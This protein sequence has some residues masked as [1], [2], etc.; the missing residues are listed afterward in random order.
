MRMLLMLLLLFLPTGA[1]SDPQSLYEGKLKFTVPEGF[2]PMSRELIAVKFPRANAP[3]HVY[4]DAKT[5]TSIAFTHSVSKLSDE[6]LEEFLGAM[7]SMLPGL[8]PGLKWIKKEIVVIQD[9]RWACLEFTTP[10]ADSVIHNEILATPMGGR[11]LLVNLNTVDSL[12]PSVESKL[13]AVKAS[14]RLAP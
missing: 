9:H 12:L 3:Q 4:A 2:Q 7:V 11:A 5:T 8:K 13:A 1:W 6:R 10:G 14:L